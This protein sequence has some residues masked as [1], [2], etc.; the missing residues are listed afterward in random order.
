LTVTLGII[1]FWEGSL[2]STAM[3]IGMPPGNSKSCLSWP[4]DQ[5]PTL[6]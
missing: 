6:C 3:T 1:S 4:M 5:W 2:I